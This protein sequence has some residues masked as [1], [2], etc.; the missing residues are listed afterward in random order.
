MLLN[1]KLDLEWKYKCN[2]KFM[3][4]WLESSDPVYGSVPTLV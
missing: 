3:K 2:G 4:K 1:F